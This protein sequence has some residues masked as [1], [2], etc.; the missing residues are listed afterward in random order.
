[1]PVKPSIKKITVALQGGGAHGAFTWGILQRLL[2]DERIEIIGASGTSAGAMNAAVLIQGLS[3]NGRIGA[4]K[5]LKKYWESLTKIFGTYS[6]YKPTFIDNISKYYNLDRSPGYFMMETLQSSFSP[7]EFN[8]MG[9]NPFFEFLVDFFNFE[10]LQKSNIGLFLATTE[11]QSGKIKVWENKEMSPEV[12]MASACLPFLY[13]AVKI[14]E[15]FYWDGGYLA[16][17]A[18]FPLIDNCKCNDIVIIQLTRMKC[19]KLPTTRAEIQD[20]LK[21]ITYNGCLMR[22]IRA[23]HLITKLIDNGTI[24]EGK[25]KRCNIHLIKN[26]DSFK[27]LNMSSV[28][29]TDEEFI[30]FL[31]KEGYQTASTWLKEHFVDIDSKKTIEDI[32]QEFV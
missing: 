31:Y 10:I 7:Y 26:E 17:P 29:N 21:E 28:F 11:I 6:P 2:E 18:I 8:P 27:N 12:L 9:I 14:N 24:K 23:I 13:H 30:K 3:E 19:N 5:M 1:M 25:M 32:E 15:K 20:R 16:N 22:E 4:Q